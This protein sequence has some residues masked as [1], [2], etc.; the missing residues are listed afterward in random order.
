ME[1]VNRKIT[2][3]LYPN[4]TEEKA[5]MVVLAMHCRLYNTL[6]EE[7]KTRYEAGEPS[8]HGGYDPVGEPPVDNF[9]YKDQWRANRHNSFVAKLHEVGVDWE[10][11]I[12]PE[13]DFYFEFTDTYHDSK[14]TEYLKGTLV[15]KDGTEQ[16]WI[17]EQIEVTNVFGMMAM[18]SEAPEKF[19]V[20]FGINSW[21]FAF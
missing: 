3:K 16:F 6:L 15:L 8:Y 9:D 10:K 14:K 17:A 18:V 13:S 1:N 12:A 21:L 20:V 11:T 7:H 4:A 19:K 5:L 2:Y